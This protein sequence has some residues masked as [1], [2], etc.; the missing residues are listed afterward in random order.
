MVLSRLS[1]W[2]GA[3]LSVPFATALGIAAQAQSTARPLIT[4]P[5]E[6]SSLVALQG[7][8][9]PLAR[10]QF[11]RGPAPASLGAQRQLLVLKRS[12]QQ[13][14]MLQQY[15]ASLEDKNS[16]NFHRFLTPAQFGQQYGPA[17][18]DVAQIVTWLNG[19]G[20]AVNK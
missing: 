15:L 10:P 8:V 4:R 17:P 20:L 7:N 6:G 3:L 18:E 11:D 16:S 2:K 14:R 12:P 5:A 19:Q 9:H 1:L 13:E